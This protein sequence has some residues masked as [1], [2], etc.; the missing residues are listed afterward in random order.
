[1]E[2]D[3]VTPSPT[4]PEDD[5]N[6][7]NNDEA[8]IAYI[9]HI[10]EPQARAHEQAHQRLGERVS[11]LEK[12]YKTL[13]QEHSDLKARYAALERRL[14]DLDARFTNLAGMWSRENHPGK[15]TESDNLHHDLAGE[16]E[17]FLQGEVFPFVI[18]PRPDGRRLRADIQAMAYGRLNAVLFGPARP[19]PDAVRVVLDEFG[20][21]YTLSEIDVLCASAASLTARAEKL[22]RNQHWDFES[23]ER[24]NPGRQTRYAGSADGGNDEVVAFV[25]APGYVVG[26]GRPIVR[27]QVFT[28]RSPA[29]PPAPQPRGD[30][31]AGDHRA[32]PPRPEGTGEL[33]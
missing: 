11:D 31:T 6:R 9:H 32:R 3:L 12:Q 23:G 30:T 20:L 18:S 21:G 25:V 26:D 8:L 29:R 24:F 28:T 14:A 2:A 16:Y 4:G 15:Q 17:Q 27:Q 10:I 13:G 33:G 5:M 22:G 7:R 1:V 19:T